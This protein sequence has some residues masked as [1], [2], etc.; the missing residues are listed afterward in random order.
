MPSWAG[1]ESIRAKVW[2]WHSRVRAGSGL[3]AKRPRLKTS[4]WDA[5]PAD[6]T[7]SARRRPNALAVQRPA[8]DAS[9]GL[10]PCAGR[11]AQGPGSRTKDT[12]GEPCRLWGEEARGA[13]GSAPA[14][15][16]Q[17][18][19]CSTALPVSL[20]PSAPGRRPQT[21]CARAAPAAACCR[22]GRRAG[23]PAPHPAPVWR[24]SPRRPPGPARSE[25]AARRLHHKDGRGGRA[26]PTAVR[27]CSGD[28]RA[29]RHT[30]GVAGEADM[31]GEGRCGGCRVQAR[32][33][34]AGLRHQPRSG[35]PPT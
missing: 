19:H 6:R 10:K 22:A 1:T 24:R 35:A 15:S 23:R 33:P 25:P 13:A 12:L 18:E 7:R 14:C 2:F 27:L 21:R 16:L 4:V 28:G 11:R 9:V 8:L 17:M 31:H 5:A 29:Q 34:A 20:C 30:C 32:H 3:P 26:S